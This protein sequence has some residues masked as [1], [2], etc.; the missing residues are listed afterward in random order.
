[1]AVGTNPLS[2]SA[3]RALGAI[4]RYRWRICALL[5]F[6]TTLNYTDRQVLGVLAPEL[7]RVIGWNEIQYG[8]IVTAFTAAYALGLLMAGQFIDRAGT[9]MG[10]AVAIAVWSVATIGHSLARTV[11]AFAVARFALG[12]AESANFPAAVKTVAEWLPQRERAL[13]TGIFN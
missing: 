3:E 13:A 8:N 11:V 5:F 4:G 1:M 12:L 7:Q 10:Y 9:R 6:I 2:A